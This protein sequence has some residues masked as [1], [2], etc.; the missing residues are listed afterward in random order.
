[1][2]KDEKR[3]RQHHAVALIEAGRTVADILVDIGAADPFL[4]TQLMPAT[5]EAARQRG[6][7]A[8]LRRQ[9][10]YDHAY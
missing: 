7:T 2:G 9:P 4:E 1:M 3:W 8:S 6:H 10:G 5:L